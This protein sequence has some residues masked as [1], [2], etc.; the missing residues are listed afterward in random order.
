[1][2]NAAYTA[3]IESYRVLPR[4]GP[5]PAAVKRSL[6]AALV[7]AC[8]LVVAADRAVAEIKLF[9][10]LEDTNIEQMEKFV[11]AKAFKVGRKIGGRTLSAVGLNFSQYFLGIVEANVPGISLSG[12][13]L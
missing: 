3:A 11:A 5:V 12:S 8:L 1:M 6:R 2:L 10:R 9:D 7:L 13:T 4:F